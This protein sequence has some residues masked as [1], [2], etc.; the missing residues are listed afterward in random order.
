MSK[1]TENS[2]SKNRKNGENRRKVFYVDLGVYLKHEICLQSSKN[3]AYLTD[4]FYLVVS[5][6]HSIK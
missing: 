5:A 2:N 3:H 4:P 6:C 1:G